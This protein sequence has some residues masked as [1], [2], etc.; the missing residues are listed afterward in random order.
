MR[1]GKARSALIAEDNPLIARAL[2]TVVQKLGFDVTMV[3]D[4]ETARQIVFATPPDL[5]IV[6]IGLPNVSG[7]SLIRW[8]KAL[9][10]EAIVVAMSGMGEAAGEMALAAGADA[11]L[12]KP[13]Q[14]NDLV[15][16]IDELSSRTD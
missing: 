14:L 7:A 10:K 13:F 16:M 2:E 9:K 5:L 6:D 15:G 3:T 4:G 1:K 8:L 11:F 12:A